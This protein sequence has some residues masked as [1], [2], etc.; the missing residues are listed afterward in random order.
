MDCILLLNIILVCLFDFLSGG[1]TF[2]IM[3]NMLVVI[4]ILSNILI[5]Q[6]SYRYEIAIAEAGTQY[7]IDKTKFICR[8][9]NNRFRFLVSFFYRNGV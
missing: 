5:G 3:I 6:L 9:E 1:V 2:L 8:M 4:V 7:S